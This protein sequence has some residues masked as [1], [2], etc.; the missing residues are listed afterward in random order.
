MSYHK[1]IIN[2]VTSQSEKVLGANGVATR[3]VRVDTAQVYDVQIEL[4]TADQDVT[5]RPEML[6]F[7]YDSDTGYHMDIDDF[8]WEF[9]KSE[10][11]FKETAERYVTAIKEGTLYITRKKMFGFMTLKKELLIK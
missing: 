9:D 8:S 5:Y 1:E 6:A 2:S 3:K 7:S 4:V 10:A 11:D